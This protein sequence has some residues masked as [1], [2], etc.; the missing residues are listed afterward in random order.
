MR[1]SARGSRTQDFFTV[2]NEFSEST[3]IAQVASHAVRVLDSNCAAGGVSPVGDR[4]LDVTSALRSQE[5]SLAF[6]RMLEDFRAFVSARDYQQAGAVQLKALRLVRK[7]ADANWRFEFRKHRL[8]VAFFFADHGVDVAATHF[9]DERLELL[10]FASQFLPNNVRR[11]DLESVFNRAMTIATA[12]ETLSSRLPCSL[13]DLSAHLQAA[14][15]GRQRWFLDR[16][17]RNKE[18][19]TIDGIVR[20]IEPEEKLTTAL[21]GSVPPIGRSLSNVSQMT[22][23]QRRFYEEVFRPSFLT[24]SPVNL[25][26]HHGYVLVL[27][28]ELLRSRRKNADLLPTALGLAESIG[29]GEDL[30][31][32]ANRWLADLEF[33]KRRWNCGFDIK[34]RV[35]LTLDDVLTRTLVLPDRRLTVAELMNISGTTRRLGV[36][37]EQR[38]SLVESCMQSALDSFHELRGVSLLADLWFRIVAHVEERSQFE[39]LEG[40]VDPYIE[41]DWALERLRNAKRLWRKANDPAMY[42]FH[43]VSPRLIAWP[44]RLPD[45]QA[46]LAFEVILARLQAEFRRAENQARVESG[47]P[48]IGEGW[49]SELALFNLVATAFPDLEV[50]H[51]GRPPWLGSQSLDIYLPQ[52]NVAIE[53]QGIQHL[54]PVGLFG[55]EVAFVAQVERDERKKSLCAANDCMLIE[56]YPGYEFV[57]VESRIRRAIQSRSAE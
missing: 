24:G 57:E 13:R 28:R 32:Q 12:R 14:G 52:V 34:A 29:E 4:F 31:Y 54:Q 56:V 33:V 7:N 17:E 16:L 43:G 42:A 18:I 50:R 6:R 9:S 35:G 37:A 3:R 27:L 11:M 2:R 38:P 46:S 5:L 51:Q 15:L 48:R 49:V 55:G 36:F 8:A 44:S 47:L 10:D 30:G 20:F 23:L 25:Q 40:E 45:T 39:W 41:P 53:Y 26:G 21:D 22:E 19:E 1:C